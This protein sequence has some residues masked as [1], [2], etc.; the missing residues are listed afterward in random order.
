MSGVKKSVVF[1]TECDIPC[2]SYAVLLLPRCE[3]LRQI[4]FAMGMDFPVAPAGVANTIA[5]VAAFLW[6]SILRS[7]QVISHV[8]HSTAACWIEELPCIQKQDIFQLYFWKQTQTDEQIPLARL[9]SFVTAHRTS[10][11]WQKVVMSEV[12]CCSLNHFYTHYIL[13]MHL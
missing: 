2:G 7:H 1:W 11:S 8:E 13:T 12:L 5:M 9:C 10:F 6:F 4:Q 3:Q